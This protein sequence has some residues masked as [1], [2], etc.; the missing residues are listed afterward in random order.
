MPWSSVR[1]SDRLT[2][3]FLCAVEEALTSGA[4]HLE[5]E[6]RQAHITSTQTLYS[7]TYILLDWITLPCRFGSI[8][9]R[10][11]RP[12]QSLELKEVYPIS[13][14]EKDAFVDTSMVLGITAWTFATMY[15]STYNI[16]CRQ[17]VAVCTMYSDSLASHKLQLMLI[18]LPP[19]NGILQSL[20]H[21]EVLY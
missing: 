13:S 17:S 1:N 10:A 9:F 7:F 2:G 16:V 8:F 21:G 18:V 15:V 11:E 4:A 5:L 12:L 19:A 14:M 20:S 6:A 3:R